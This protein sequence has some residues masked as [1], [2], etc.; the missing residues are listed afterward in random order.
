[1]DIFAFVLTGVMVSSSLMFQQ[2]D[3]CTNDE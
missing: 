3:G 1:M 2:N